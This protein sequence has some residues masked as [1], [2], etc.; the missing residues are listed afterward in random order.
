MGWQGDLSYTI[1]EFATP[2]DTVFPNIDDE[3]G[4]DGPFDVKP[5]CF[6]LAAATPSEIVNNMGFLSP[7]TRLPFS[8]E[9]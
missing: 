6:D 3:N 2:P 7:V 1:P 4:V 9:V 8:L 5:I